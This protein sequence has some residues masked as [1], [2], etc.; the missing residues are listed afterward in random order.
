MDGAY[1]DEAGSL[2][3]QYSYGSWKLRHYFAGRSR[4]RKRRP[5]PSGRQ[6]G[7][8][9]HQGESVAAWGN[10][11]RADSVSARGSNSKIGDRNDRFRLDVR[12][13]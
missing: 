5:A 2:R 13:R 11:S 3:H 6:A 8:T 7:E 1:E 9:G 10:S 12:P 4:G